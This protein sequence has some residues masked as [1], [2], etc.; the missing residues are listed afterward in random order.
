MSLI[1]QAVGAISK[2]ISGNVHLDSTDRPAGN[3]GAEQQQMEIM[4]LMTKGFRIEKQKK[5]LQMVTAPRSTSTYSSSEARTV[6]PK[7]DLSS[8][9]RLFLSVAVCDIKVGWSTARAQDPVLLV[10]LIKLFVGMTVMGGVY[11]PPEYEVVC[12][13]LTLEDW[14]YGVESN[15][16]S[17]FV[18]ILMP[19]AIILNDEVTFAVRDISQSILNLTVYSENSLPSLVA[20][21]PLCKLDLRCDVKKFEG[22]DLL[23]QLTHFT[24]SNDDLNNIVYHMISSGIDFS[25]LTNL[26]LSYFTSMKDFLKLNAML[27]SL[28]TFG[29]IN[30]RGHQHDLVV[31]HEHQQMIPQRCTL[32][33]IRVL[34]VLVGQL[35]EFSFSALIEAMVHSFKGVKRLII[36]FCELKTPLDYKGFKLQ[37]GRA[38]RSTSLLVVI[39]L[40]ED[41]SDLLEFQQGWE[42]L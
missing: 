8:K 18:S 4:Q 38:R 20:F 28:T 21:S 10:H 1:K 32:R 22:L 19:R 3:D 39:I 5:Q 25:K 42:S 6:K 36:D 37:L 35:N 23:V 29:T 14:D 16:I 17:K 11:G 33:R 34:K 24:T 9:S 7:Q 41:K 40:F 26:I 2:C 31:S 13:Q 12:S 27:P 30:L 15:N